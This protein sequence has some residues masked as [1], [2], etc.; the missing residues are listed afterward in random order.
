M[1]NPINRINLLIPLPLLLE[2]IKLC[3]LVPIDLLLLRRATPVLKVLVNLLL[4]GSLAALVLL[5]V[6]VAVQ[7]LDAC[8]SEQVEVYR[9]RL[10]RF[11]TMAKAALF[12]WVSARSSL[13][14]LA[15]VDFEV[16]SLGRDHLTLFS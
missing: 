11:V 15:L 14:Q 9:A 3:S 5:E 4:Q 12:G 2:A 7:F 16:R 6:V 10:L 13:H 8:L 1:Y